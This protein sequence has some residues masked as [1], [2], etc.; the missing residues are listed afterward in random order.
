MKRLETELKLR[1]ASPHTIAAYRRYNQQLLD[2]SKKSSEQITKDDIKLFLGHLIADKEFSSR[3]VNL[4]RSA[5][6]FFYEQVL[7]KS[8]GSIKTPKIEKSLPTVLSKREIK[9]LI[10]AC[11]NRKSKMI[12]ELLYSSG[13]RVSELVNLKV[14]DFEDKIGW[15][16]GGKGKK[17]RAFI[18]SERILADLRHFLKTKGIG[19][20]HIFRNRKGGILSP[21]NIQKIVSTAAKKANIQKHVT[22]H[23]LRHSFATH[24]LE[25][26][27]DIRVIQELLG[28]SNL[29]TTQIYTHIS[30]EQIKK[31]ENP[32]DKLSL[33]DNN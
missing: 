10:N 21:R 28:H 5:I 19:E 18:L 2:F 12:I 15:V 17:D 27:T 30:T 11:N 31:V 26:G 25:N 7:E 9:Q 13:L 29:N 22:P 14:E 1:G 33:D 32:L 20:G 6:Y 24:L 4:A 3:S 16:R 8:L 23:K